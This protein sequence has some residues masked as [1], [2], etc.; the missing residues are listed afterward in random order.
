MCVPVID[1]LPVL[2]TLACCCAAEPA[3]DTSPFADISRSPALA[4]SCASDRTPIPAAVLIT[5]IWP[6]VI[7]PNA[8]ASIAS[9]RFAP[10]FAALIAAAELSEPFDAVPYVVPYVSVAAG[11]TN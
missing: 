1:T 7:A 9:E 6:A 4:A 5:W 11:I 8:V 3:T 10:P 2:W